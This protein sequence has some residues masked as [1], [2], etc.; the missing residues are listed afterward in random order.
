[1]GHIQSRQLLPASYTSLISLQSNDGILGFTENIHIQRTPIQLP[2]LKKITSL[3]A[4]SNHVLALDQKGNVFAWGSGQQNQLGRRVVERTRLAGLVPREFGLPKG[5][6]VSISCGSYHSFAITKD[7][8][9]YSWGLNSF[10]ETGINDGAGDDNAVIFKPTVVSDLKDYDIKE[11]KGGGHH[12][13]AC[14]TDGQLLVWGRADGSQIGMKLSDIPKEHFI[15]DERG[16]AR[17]LKKPTVIPGKSSLLQS[18]ESVNN[19]TGINA[20][21]VTAGSDSCFA[22]DEQGRAF[23]WGF[24]ANYQT[25]LGTDDDVELATLIENTAVKGKK[26]VGAGAGGQFGVLWGYHL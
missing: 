12:S 14:T 25:G 7:N 13:L 21:T 20:V 22:I 15:Y 24:S 2:E 23:S 17:I 19:F 10:G 1:M 18:V 16:A 6:I 11:I 3:A 5:K 4:G 8:K 26:L 9:V